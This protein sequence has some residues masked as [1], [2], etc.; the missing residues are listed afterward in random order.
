[1][2]VAVAAAAVAPAVLLDCG[3]SYAW[4]DPIK[5][6]NGSFKDSRFEIHH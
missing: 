3:G 6:K 4:P 2:R 5:V 1:M